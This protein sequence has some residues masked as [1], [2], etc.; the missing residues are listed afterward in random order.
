MNMVFFRLDFL[1]F[2]EIWYVTILLSN[3]KLCSVKSGFPAIKSTL[4]HS[5]NDHKNFQCYR[6]LAFM[7]SHIWT[8]K[9]KVWKP[10]FFN[11]TNAI[12]TFLIAS[13]PCGYKELWMNG[14]VNFTI[15]I[16]I[17]YGF[18]VKLDFESW[19]SQRFFLNIFYFQMKFQM[20]PIWSCTT[21]DVFFWL[22]YEYP[23][24][25]HEYSSLW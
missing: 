4:F 15:F 7:K 18:I 13:F 22:S 25:S 21:S 20:V 11:R 3:H 8:K 10:P 12:P 24:P 19:F 16:L 9:E 1:K 17:C 5:Y 6:P 2:P 14:I 23:S